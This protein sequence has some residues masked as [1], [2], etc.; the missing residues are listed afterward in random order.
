VKSALAG[1]E[2]ALLENGHA[3]T[4]GMTT[5]EFEKIVKI[6]SPPR[7]S[8]TGRLLTEMIYQPM[9]R[10]VCICARTASRLSSCLAAHRVHASW[11]KKFMAFLRNRSSAAASRR[12]SKCATPSRALRLPEPTSSTTRPA[13]RWHPATHRPPSIAAFGNS[14]GDLQMLQ[15]TPLALARAS[16]ST[17][18]YDAERSLPTT[19]NRTSA[20][21]TRA[22]MKPPPK[23]GRL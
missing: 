19:A 5:E 11:T 13:S 22:S 23:A 17:S 6:G 14:D 7:A 15:W 16:A 10:A 21:S 1:G 9:P 3:D 8:K 4:R 2:H 20:S 12:N 18:S